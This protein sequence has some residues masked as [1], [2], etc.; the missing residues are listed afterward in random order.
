MA[1]F[2]TLSAFDEDIWSLAPL[3]S[4]AVDVHSSKVLMTSGTERYRFVGTG[5]YEDGS[6]VH[7]TIQS[8]TFSDSSLGGAVFKASGL[9]LDFDDF[10]L[11]VGTNDPQALLSLM[12]SGADAITGTNGN[13]V[14]YGYAGND[15]FRMGKGGNDTVF[16]G[17]DND[18][19]RF[20]GSFT[21]DDKVDGGAGYDTLKLNGS[22]TV[23]FNA[24]TMVGV[25]RVLLAPGTYNLTLND[26]NVASGES[27]LIA[28]HQFGSSDSLTVDGSAETDGSLHL[29]GGLGDDHLIGGAGDDVLVGR[30]GDDVLSDAA[31]TNRFNL[32]GGGDD[33]AT[34]GTGNDTF[35]FDT[36]FDAAD[37]VDGG[38]GYNTLVLN[39]FDEFGTGVD[40]SMGPPILY[41]AAD[42]MTNIDRIQFM[43]GYDYF[44]ALNDGNVAAG[45]T[46]LVDGSNLCGCYYFYFDG[47]A[48]MDGNLQILGS[49]GDDILIAGHGNDVLKGGYGDDYLLFNGN[50]TPNDQAYG[51]DGYDVLILDGDYSAGVKMKGTTI[52]DVEMI[53]LT[54]GHSYKLIMNDGNVAAGETLTVDG[55]YLGHANAL[56]DPTDTLY[57]DGSGEK[58]GSFY[59]AGGYGSDT[60]L[61]GAQDDV[62][63]G[64]EGADHISGGGGDDYIDGGE[65]NN[66]LDGG[67]GNDQIIGC[68]GIDTITG[69][70]GDDLI[71]GDAMGDILDGGAGA[72]TF[73]YYFASESTGTKYDTIIGF[74][75]DEDFIA[76][77]GLTVTAIAATVTSGNLTTSSFNAKLAAAIGPDQLG[78]HEA[79][80]FTPTTGNL[81]GHTFL[82]VDGDGVAGY[83]SGQDYVIDLKNP[84]NIGH[85][86]TGDF[87]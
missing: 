80:L 59:V 60:L 6:G 14:L 78:A 84:V 70:N 68:D 69:G 31:G 17:A 16:G 25:E 56:P 34:G 74:D 54:E 3:Q 45:H 47:S 38:G 57:F 66:V 55:S 5:F 72:D 35:L 33:T 52:H 41:F 51:G 28:A 65:G 62:F 39:G 46:L 2:S 10:N 21:S 53:S 22:T 13:D 73:Q 18:E 24:D 61:G 49:T 37:K 36:Y 1:K 81:A 87:I 32:F 79:V 64:F 19:F 27:L 40:D 42:T 50:L 12:L 77:E 44:I 67:D 85:L 75:A 82:I 58:D 4:A 63:F 86:G 7:G 23:V 9:N 83:T 29:Q 15:L 20:G 26:G 8:L 30:G 11:L 43:P 76:I 71:Y 48:E